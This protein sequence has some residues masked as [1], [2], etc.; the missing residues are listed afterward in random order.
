MPEM[1]PC[2][3]LITQY[4]VSLK[5]SPSSK[6]QSRRKKQAADDDYEDEE[7]VGSSD[8]YLDPSNESDYQLISK[9][10][11]GLRG[12]GGDEEDWDTIQ[13]YNTVN[14]SEIETPVDKKRDSSSS[15]SELAGR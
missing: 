14:A 13:P 15:S 8:D 4:L 12:G 11:Q 6:C 1:L 7:V 2:P 9:L 3:L 10:R 5:E